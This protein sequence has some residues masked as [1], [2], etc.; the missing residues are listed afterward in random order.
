MSTL[1]LP[2]LTTVESSESPDVEVSTVSNMLRRTA[3]P[4]LM[5]CLR[6]AQQLRFAVTV[7]VHSVLFVLG[8][9]GNT[10][11]IL[12]TKREKI[13]S[14]SARLLIVALAVSDILFLIPR[15]IQYPMLNIVHRLSENMLSVPYFKIFAIVYVDCVKH[16]TDTL[17]CFI[18]V[19][20]G[21]VRY[22]AV[23]WPFKAASWCTVKKVR[24]QIILSI[25]LSVAL[26]I[27]LW[28]RFEFPY[29][30]K[31]TVFGKTF[32]FRIYEPYVYNI[33]I[34][35]ICFTVIS[36]LNIRLLIGLR[37]AAVRRLKMSSNQ[38]ANH[39]ETK[40][41]THE[42]RLTLAIVGIL[43]MFILCHI[44][45]RLHIVL[46]TAG[47]WDYC[48]P[49]LQV[50]LIGQAMVY[51]NSCLNI[52]VYVATKQEFRKQL[53]LLFLCR[54]AQQEVKQTMINIKSLSTNTNSYVKEGSINPNCEAHNGNAALST[55]AEPL[56][57][58]Y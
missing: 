7:V 20:N 41:P 47:L 42:R 8:I 24:C 49:I 43:T 50:T 57:E 56:H 54:R 40:R 38:T 29:N 11:I 19:L 51:L 46:L 39:I 16:F 33:G 25:L 12:V 4:E 37:Q 45:A 17:T 34:F 14:S 18:T 26:A 48:G 23:C 21:V 15:F 44:P 10:L 31:R 9:V 30:G 32:L 2:N 13:S 52:F 1:H 53:V 27:P 36:A 35:F 3:S 58:K 5:E 22:I 28:F 55:I 6:N